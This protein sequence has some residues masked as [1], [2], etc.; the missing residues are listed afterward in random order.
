[1]TKD[2]KVVKE[3]IA[4]FG[5][6]LNLKKTPHVILEIIRQFGPQVGQNPAAECL[7]PGGPPKLQDP[8]E[9]V[10]LLKARLS[11]LTKLSA[12]LQK[13]IRARPR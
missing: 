9:L 6:T 12:S 5:D 2:E 7:P 10:K 8:E 1:M 13:S 3:I 4:R 11:E